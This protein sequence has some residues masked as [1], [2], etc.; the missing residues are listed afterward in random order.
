MLEHVGLHMLLQVFATN[1]YLASHLANGAE[2]WLKRA[3]VSMRLKVLAEHLLPTALGAR[4]R[5]G[6]TFLKMAASYGLTFSFSFAIF[7][8]DEPLSAL[9]L[10][11][12]LHLSTKHFSLTLVSAVQLD[13]ETAFIVAR[14]DMLITFSHLEH[15]LAAMFF[16]RTVHLQLSNLPAPLLEQHVRE[17]PGAT[18]RAGLVSNHPLLQTLLTELLLTTIHHVGLTQHF[19]ADRASHLFRELLNKLVL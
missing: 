2:H 18:V 14:R 13:I 12:C 17:H 11:V 16:V 3:V 1:S 15:C 19:H 9:L 10:H 6:G 5:V 8:V 4:E 7:A